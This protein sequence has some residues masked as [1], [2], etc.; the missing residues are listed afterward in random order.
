M[1]MDLVRFQIAILKVHITAPAITMEL[2]QMKNGCI[3]IGFIQ[4]IMVF[5]V[6]K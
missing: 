5:L 6:M 3:D 4:K 2:I 1:K